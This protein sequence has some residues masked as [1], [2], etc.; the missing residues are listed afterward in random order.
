MDEGI[1]PE[2]KLESN[3]LHILV[4]RIC[5]LISYKLS[6][7]STYRYE[8]SLRLP[9]LGEIIPLNPFRQISLHQQVSD[10]YIGN[11]VHEM[12]SQTYILVRAEA[13]YK[14]LGIGPL[15]LFE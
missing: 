2:R 4:V 12:R 14:V 11:N 15:K 10:S 5:L 3:P 1:S 7:S 9:I 8:R 6:K 13:E